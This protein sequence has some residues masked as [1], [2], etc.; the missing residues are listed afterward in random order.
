MKK[1]LNVL[2]G[3]LESC[4]MQP[5]TGY[6]RD[7]YCRTDETDRGTHI[8][9]AI[10]T[11]D[12]L[13]FSAARGNDLMTPKPQWDFAGLK[14]GDKWCLCINRWLEAVDADKAP[15][16][17]LEATHKDALQFATIELLKKYSHKEA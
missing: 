9:C 10:V 1:E 15:T 2:G 14:E 17:I 5:V 12:F 8:V 7:G 11:N 16:I 6:F 13:N 4:C 3:E